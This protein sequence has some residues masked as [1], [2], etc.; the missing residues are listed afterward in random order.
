MISG[1]GLFAYWTANFLFEIIKTEIPVVL[2]LGLI[3][4]FNEELPMV[5]IVF[6]VFPFGLVPFTIGLSYLFKSDS[7][8]M[9]TVMFVNFVIGG[10]GSIAVFVLT[11]IE[12]TYDWADYL[13]WVFRGIPIFSVTHTINF[14][15]SKG[16]YEFLRPDWDVSN[17]RWIHSGGDIYFLLFHFAFWSIFIFIN[18]M[19]FI[20]NF[21]Y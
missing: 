15:A 20:K 7:S 19:P 1:M 16:S 5:W 6:L 12:S 10:L 14:Q 8:A 9:S 2:S 11:I 13:T 21:N 17:W 4:A 3:Y 18:E